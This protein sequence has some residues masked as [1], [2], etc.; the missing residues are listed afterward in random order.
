M[1]DIES[2]ILEYLL[3]SLWQVP[4]IFAAGATAIPTMQV[5][6]QLGDGRSSEARSPHSATRPQRAI[7]ASVV[8]RKPL[9]ITVGQRR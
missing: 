3:N 4:V 6:S 2:K 5:T 1:S 9:A 8:M 7:N